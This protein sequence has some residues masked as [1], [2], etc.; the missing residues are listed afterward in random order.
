MTSSNTQREANFKFW[1][2]NFSSVGTIGFA[3]ILPK[4]SG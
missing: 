3:K 1:A 4:S 2:D